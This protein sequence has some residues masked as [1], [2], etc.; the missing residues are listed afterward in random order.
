MDGLVNLSN[1]YL[2][3]NNIKKIQNLDTLTQLKKLY[4]G[5][6][7]ISV[8]ENLQKLINLEELY[9]EKQNLSNGDSLCFDPRSIDG[10]AVTSIF[11]YLR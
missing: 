11:S 8:V 3:R 7:E 6:N 4:L 1:L 5:Q 2:Q 10:L 9:I